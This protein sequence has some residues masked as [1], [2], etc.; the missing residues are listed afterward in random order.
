MI[1]YATV[2]EF[3]TL[4]G[5]ETD[6]ADADRILREYLQK[7]TRIIDTYTRRH[8]APQMESFDYV[9]P[10]EYFDLRLRA[11]V[12]GD[13]V[14]DQDLLEPISVVTGTGDNATTLVEG[15]HYNLLPFNIFPKWGIRLIDPS[16]WKSV[17]TGVTSG[18]YKNPSIVV[19]GFNGFHEQYAR[20]YGGDGCTEAWVGINQTLSGALDANTATLVFTGVGLL[21][22]FGDTAV[23]AGDLLRIDN[24]LLQVL[25]VTES[26]NTTLTVLRGANGSTPASHESGALI[27]RW[28]SQPD[29]KDICFKIAKMLRDHDE[30][31]GGRQGVS[32]MS[33][34]VEL[35]MPSNVKNLIM[36]YVRSSTGQ[37]NA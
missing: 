37:T 12:D 36:R 1:T 19:T 27:R 9:I 33:I 30:A 8:F 28:V 11:I 15:T 3:R 22:D 24:E 5:I 2:R 4:K 34:G 10:S 6:D 7:A 32:E 35:E 25:T 23:T 16:Y 20:R 29:I 21:D 18:S 17:Y 13:I 26:G 31:T 14:L